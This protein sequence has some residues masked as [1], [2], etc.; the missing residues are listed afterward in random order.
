MTEDGRGEA[1]R[2]LIYLQ[3]SVGDAA[4]L[5]RAFSWDSKDE[6]VVMTKADLV[7]LLDLYLQGKLDESQVEQW[8]ETIEGRDDIGYEAEVAASLQHAIFELANPDI[9]RRLDVNV[10]LALK[11]S[12]ALASS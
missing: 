10:A 12:L 9:T 2:R 5:V 3:D 8:A 4:R 6:L 11:E 7:H 1:L